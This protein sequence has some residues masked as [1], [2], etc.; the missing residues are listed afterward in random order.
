MKKRG[1]L[2]SRDGPSDNVLKIK[3]PIVLSYSG[4]LKSNNTFEK[5]FFFFNFF[6]SDALRAVNLLDCCLTNLS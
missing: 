3:P 4:N 1:V 5:S 6:F 2:I